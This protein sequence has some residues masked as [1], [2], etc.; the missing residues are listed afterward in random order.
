MNHIENNFEMN[1]L[2]YEF[3]S[4]ILIQV[5]NKLFEMFKQFGEM[6]NK[7]YFSYSVLWKRNCKKKKTV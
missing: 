6:A 7:F 3:D 4:A 5:S 1:V 2:T